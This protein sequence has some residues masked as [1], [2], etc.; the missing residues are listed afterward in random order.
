MGK[1]EGGELKVSFRLKRDAACGE[2]DDS[3]RGSEVILNGW[4]AKR[5]D[6]GGLIFVDLRDDTGVLQVV[7]DP[8]ASEEA[9]GVAESI[10]PEYVLGVAGEVRRRPD[11]TE[12]PSMATGTV[13]VLAGDVEVINPS[14]TPPFEIKPETNVDEKIRLKYR[15]LDLRRDDLHQVLKVR[16][17]IVKAARD[18][19]DSE[20]FIDIETPQL[21][22]STPEGARDYLVPSRVQPGRFYALPQSPQLFKQTLMISGFE[23]YYQIARCFRDEDLR[24]DRQ[25]E[26]TQVDIEM[27]FVDEDDIMGVV[28]GLMAA[29]FGAVGRKLEIP[30]P[31]MPYSRAIELYGTDRPDLRYG[32]NMATLDGVFEGTGFKVFAGTLKSG[33]SIRGMRV[34]GGQSMTRS[35]LDGWTGR[36]RELGAAGLVW[37][38]LEEGGL[39]SPVAKFLI[40]EE[41]DGLTSALRMQPGDAAF[42]VAGDRG[43]CDEVMHQLRTDVAKKL[44]LAGDEFRPTWIVDFPLLENDPEAGRYRS[45]HHPFTS[46]TEESLA[47]LPDEPLAARA[48]AYD[49]VMNGVEI[50]GGSV[51]IHRR[52]VQE[53]MFGLL[54]IP[55]EEY[56]SRFGFLLE[57]LQYGAPPHGGIAMGLDRLVMLLT[58]RDTIR[59]TIAFPKTQS[60]SCLMTGA[61]DEVAPGQIR[62]LGLK[63]SFE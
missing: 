62:D 29:I 9:H 30:T 61:P 39:R 13:E 56:R 4:V 52:D 27:A 10:R 23:R 55:P 3:R 34:E 24:A 17:R 63:H 7:F 21:T 50:G 15:Y 46:P 51:R 22:K 59:E 8:R 53:R 16:H 2:I 43:M 38:V 57:A 37:F 18:H 58:G 26:F 6:H 44:G 54:G 5:R 40:E 49:I 14:I 20:G 1:S 31:R 19:L 60:A 25:P 12:N 33:G 45:L 32:L 42:L 35:D 41:K 28:D 36:A 48:R 47:L 11:G